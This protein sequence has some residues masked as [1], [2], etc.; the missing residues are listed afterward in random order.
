MSADVRSRSPVSGDAGAPAGVG[1]RVVAAT[2]AGAA[3]AAHLGRALPGAR[4]D[5]DRP[6]REAVIEALARGEALVCV[7][8][9]GACVRLAAPHLGDKHTD[10]PVVAVDDAARWAVCVA[11]AHH[12]GDALAARVADALGAQPVVT[13]ASASLGL[14]ALDHL[15]AEAGLHP[16]PEVADT[17]AVGAA[18]AGG[19]A[20]DH[21]ARSAAAP[22]TR[23]RDAPWPTGPLPGWVVDAEAPA[24]PGIAVTDRL[25]DLP[26]PQVCYRP[27]SLVVGVGASRGASAAEIDAAID[28][29]LADAALSP[30]SVAA[31]A[32]VAAKAGEPGLIAVAERRGVALRAHPA[33]TLA[34]VDVPHPSDAAVAAVGTPSVAEAAALVEAGGPAGGAELV[35]AKTRSRPGA[36][37]AGVDVE[38]AAAADG[39]GDG[40]GPGAGGDQTEKPAAMATVAVARRP[41]RGQL[42]LVSTGPGGEALVPPAARD[43]LASAE[44]VIGLARY[45]DAARPWLRPGTEVRPTPIGCET[46]RADDAIAGAR[47]G[48]RVALI[49]GGD[50]GVYAM[51]SPALEALG[52]AGDV[53]VEVIPGVT[54]ASAAAAALGSPLGHDHCAISLSDLL[55]PWETIAR[56]VTAAAEGDFVV[57]FYNPRSIQRRDHLAD[58]LAL[59]AP[60]RAPDTPVGVVTDASRPTQRAWLTTLAGLATAEEAA[61][62]DMRTTVIVGA[63]HTRVHRGRM[64]TPRGYA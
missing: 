21:L 19:T 42:L 40:D 32:T 59:L 39:D 12:G 26:R 20:A 3:H 37:A 47:A 34:S 55:T 17:A 31:L 6:A 24:A 8:A 58:A 36:G 48:R 7:M 28:A 33:A 46:A 64:V 1:T 18:L 23:W 57:V 52:D 10:P 30:Q 16:D 2:P 44:V 60:H 49:S 50:V 13:T 35:V 11:G 56:R 61:Q 38:G 4:A 53:D 63:T 29:A 45:V 5:A 54:A 41:A 22:V 15:G 14:P 62:V 9:V 43:A 25:V 27:P 51:G